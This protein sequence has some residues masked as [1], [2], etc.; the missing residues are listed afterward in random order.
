LVVQSGDTVMLASRDVSD[1]QLTPSSTSKD[2]E[3]LDWDRVYPLAGPI[4][5]DG[6]ERGD[7]LAV[8]IL[9]LRVQDWG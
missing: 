3:N 5:I 9:E 1:N 4:A 6:A 7:T 8:E 2:I